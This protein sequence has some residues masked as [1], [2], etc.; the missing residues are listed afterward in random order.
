MKLID[1]SFKAIYQSV[2]SNANIGSQSGVS[3]RGLSST[4]KPGKRVKNGTAKYDQ[5][6]RSEDTTISEKSEIDTYLE[7]GVYIGEPG[8]YFDAL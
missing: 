1:F 7:E 8:V 5:H 4:F 2:V 3:K 6:I